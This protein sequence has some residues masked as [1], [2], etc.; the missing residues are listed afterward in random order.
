MAAKRRD[1]PSG[2]V[3]AAGRSVRLLVDTSVKYDS[4]LRA[5]KHQLRPRRPTR[6]AS[7]RAWLEPVRVELEADASTVLQPPCLRAGRV[8]RQTSQ[9][10]R[11]AAV[12]VNGSRRTA[13]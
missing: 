3:D 7:K 4:S 11:G 2:R 12:A 9:R 1:S 13:R 6:L 10:R 8:H 5:A